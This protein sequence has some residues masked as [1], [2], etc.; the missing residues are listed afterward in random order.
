[1]RSR[2]TVIMFL[3]VAA[4]A[5]A[6]SPV[7]RQAVRQIDRVLIE[8]ADPRIL[9]DLFTGP[10]Q[11]PVSW[12]VAESASYISGGF[13]TG[14]LNIEVFRSAPPKGPPGR[15]QFAGLAFEPYSPLREVLP[16]LQSRGVSY[17]TP[18]PY[19]STLPDNTQGTVWTTVVLDGLASPG[20]RVFL[21]EY[22]PR[23]RNVN[24]GR[25]QLAG[26][27]ALKKGGPLGVVGVGEIVITSPNAQADISKWQK[28]LPAASAPGFWK[29]GKGPSLRIVPGP[30]SGI[31]AL[32]LDVSSLPQAKNHLQSSAMLGPAPRNEVA[33]RPDRVQGLTIRLRTAQP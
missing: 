14:N 15:A 32:V 5:A 4:A 1:M 26:Q 8:S 12:P 10:L 9:Y 33:I 24:V 3:I 6:Q 20:M 30:R 28:L 22:S 17:A 16:E 29:I 13:G 19:V 11:F 25:N 21:F 23:F 27:L 2:A 18:E 7:K 31:E